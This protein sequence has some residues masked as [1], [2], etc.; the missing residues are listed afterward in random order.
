MD[1]QDAAEQFCDILTLGSKALQRLAER[2]LDQLRLDALE[3]LVGDLLD[4][5][6]QIKSILRCP[7]N[8]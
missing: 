2:E 7:P 5:A 3:K 6:E 1:L 8:S 4:L